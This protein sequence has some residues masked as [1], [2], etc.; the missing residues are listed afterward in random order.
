MKFSMGALAAS[1]LFVMCCFAA[2]AWG[3]T[4]PVTVE[5]T[6]AAGQTRYYDPRMPSELMPTPQANEAGVTVAEFFC[7]ANVA[8]RVF[9]QF[10]SGPDVVCGVRVESVHIV[11]KLKISEWVD[12]T[13]GPKVLAHEDG[14]AL[15][16]RHFYDRSD[17][18]AAG[19]GREFIG[20]DFFGSGPDAETAANDAL[21]VAARQ[22]T[23]EY[24]GRVRNPS[25]LVQ[26]LYDRITEHGENQIEEL[27]AIEEAMRVMSRL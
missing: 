16:A 5:L 18:I 24:M 4:L 11:L 23:R 21:N 15:V 27:D 2:G 13:A 19:I 7:Q 20:K 25:E 17:Q 8:G 14:H 12:E 22:I 26:N 6:P 3:Q 1:A 9:E 10:N